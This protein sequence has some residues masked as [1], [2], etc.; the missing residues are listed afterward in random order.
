MSEVARRT[1]P[2]WEATTEAE[3]VS[4]LKEML[5]S[6]ASISAIAASLVAAAALSFVAP[7]GVAAIPLVAAA[8]GQSI[9]GLFIPSSPVFQ[10]RINLRKRRERRDKARQHLM[11][12]ISGQVGDDHPNWRTY[13][14]MGER[15]DS[16]QALADSRASSLTPSMV[17]QL[18]DAR[19]DYL[20]LWLAW[21]TMRQRWESTD[22]KALGDRLAQ[23]DTQLD[24][25][26]SAVDRHHLQKAR[27]D[28]RRILDRRASL[29]SRA[30][31]VEAA[32]LAMADT[33]EEVYQRVIANP[34]SSDVGNTLQD[35]VERMRV[36]EQLDLA[37]ESELSDLLG[38]VKKKKAAKVAQATAG[39]TR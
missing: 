23:I 16:L 24:R 7:L 22:E 38:D 6:N 14:R 12:E 26:E 8:A 5:A 20:G 15:L 34:N 4:Y 28:L 18:H 32:M 30:T 27:A 2:L 29:W 21:L 3:Q 11:A 19:V 1:D 36:E 35:A 33:F 17:E 31:S 37:V 25:A 9:A 13:E 39:R 10:A